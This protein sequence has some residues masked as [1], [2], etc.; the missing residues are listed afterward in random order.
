M[1]LGGI[2]H[3]LGTPCLLRLY[4]VVGHASGNDSVGFAGKMLDADFTFRSGE[5]GSI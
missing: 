1:T 2:I 4:S 3:V 5:V